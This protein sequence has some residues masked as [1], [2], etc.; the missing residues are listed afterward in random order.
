MSQEV[1]DRIDGVDRC[2]AC[3]G[4]ASTRGDLMAWQRK[5]HARQRDLDRREKALAVGERT[6]ASRVRALVNAGEWGVEGLV[7]RLERLAADKA[8]LP[9]IRR[10]A[11]RLVLDIG[12]A[13][14]SLEAEVKLKEEAMP[15]W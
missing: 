13:V 6:H 1:R 11:R 14:D 12:E 9:E 2:A 3:G 15:T 10:L 4:I 5:L 8:G 7:G